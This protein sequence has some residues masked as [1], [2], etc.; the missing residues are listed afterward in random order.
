M[1][2]YDCRKWAG[3]MRQTQRGGQRPFSAADSH[4]DLTES[5]DIDIRRWLVRRIGCAWLV[6][7]TGDLSAWVEDNTHVDGQFF[8][9]AG[10]GNN[11]PF[12]PH[13]GLALQNLLKG[14][15]PVN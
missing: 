9:L 1:H 6:S 15:N 10:E 12:L 7:Q 3:A 5:L 4:L 2:Q 11:T 8:K 13:N 14:A